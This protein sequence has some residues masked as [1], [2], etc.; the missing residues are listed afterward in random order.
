MIL[1]G[2]RR[3]VR[4]HRHALA[5]LYRGH[6]CEFLYGRGG[7]G[8]RDVGRTRQATL[9]IVRTTVVLGWTQAESCATVTPGRML[10]SNFPAKASLIPLSLRMGSAPCGLQLYFRLKE[11]RV[12]CCVQYIRAP[13]RTDD[14]A[15][16]TTARQHRTAAR[17]RRFPRR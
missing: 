10:M 11:G 17:P 4:D 1:C 3:E 9:G 16:R 7:F 15:V 6:V 2:G 14:D 5:D 8:G 13:A 12:Q